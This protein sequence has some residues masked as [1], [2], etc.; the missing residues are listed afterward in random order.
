MELFDFIENNDGTFTPD[1]IYD[2][3]HRINVK[4]K[5]GLINYI[6]KY[7]VVKYFILSPFF[8]KE[9]IVLSKL[10]DEN[11]YYITQRTGGPAI[12]IAFYLGFADDA[13]I[14]YKRTDI[15][16]YARYMHFDSEIYEEFKASDELRSYYGMLVKFLKSK[17]RQVT[18]TNGK[19]YWVSR[20][21]SEDEIL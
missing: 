11:N 9:P 14:K 4:H 13:P 6:N 5:V 1:F 20:S 2:E 16:H 12:D 10:N 21:L 3:P 8:Q 19:K 17:C 18:A 7:R 15:G